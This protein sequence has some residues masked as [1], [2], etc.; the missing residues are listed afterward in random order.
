MGLVHTAIRS[1]LG[2]EKVRKATMVG[3]A[4]KQ[5][6]VEAGLLR[7]RERR[8][9]GMAVPDEEESSEAADNLQVEGPEALLNFRQLSDQLIASATAADLPV[10]KESNNEDN[11]TMQAPALGWVP[12]PVR[13]TII[14]PPSTSTHPQ[15]QSAPARKISIALEKLFVYPTETEAESLQVLGSFWNGGMSNLAREMEVYEV[16]LVLEAGEAAA[17]YEDDHTQSQSANAMDES[18]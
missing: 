4:I 18:A 12:P 6:H 1:R 8:N 11:S 2:V 9:F 7:P 17:E 5:A 16:L 13:S 14:I 10:P 3:M 15:T